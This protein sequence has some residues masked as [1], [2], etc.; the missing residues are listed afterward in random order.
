MAMLLKITL[1]SLT[2]WDWKGLFK[3][4]QVALKSAVACC[5]TYLLATGT[6]AGTLQCPRNAFHLDPCLNWFGFWGAKDLWKSSGRASEK[7]EK[8]MW[9]GDTQVD[10]QVTS[11]ARTKAGELCQK[12][13]PSHKAVR[14]R[15]RSH[16]A[17]FRTFLV[18]EAKSRDQY[19]VCSSPWSRLCLIWTGLCQQSCIC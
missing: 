10:I 15:L 9:S 3:G 18:H 1:L 11:W 6:F 2:D 17:S 4:K 14:N 16:S 19:A 7:T 8:P 13:S 5:L 12:G